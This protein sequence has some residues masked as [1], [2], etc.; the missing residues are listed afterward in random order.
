MN[1]TSLKAG[2]AATQ[3][4]GDA[5]RSAGFPRS[6]RR[7]ALP[8]CLVAFTL[9]ELLVVIAIIGIL[10]GILIPAVGAV[11][12]SAKDAGTKALLNALGTGLETYKADAKL[13]GLYPPSFSDADGSNMPASMV[14]SPYVG[15]TMQISG[16]GLL[17]WALSG[18]DLLGTPGFAPL[19]TAAQWSQSTAGGSYTEDPTPFGA[20]YGLYSDPDRLNQPIHAR[21][22]PYVDGSKVV[23]TRN[24]LQAPNV[25]FA[26]P[27]EKKVNPSAPTRS[28]PMYLDTYGYPVLYWRADSAGRQMAD[29]NRG[30]TNTQRGIYHWEDNAALLDPIPPVPQ[31]AQVLSLN[32][33]GGTH[34]LG[35]DMEF[36]T[37]AAGTALVN[38]SFP[39]FI[40]NENVNARF[41]PSRPDSYLLVSPGFDGLYG[42]ADDSTNFDHH[43]Q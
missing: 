33:G 13:G 39:R 6:S 37:V 16:A 8:R 19:G 21:Y 27:E 32:K 22:G 15:M 40:C 2:D 36:R 29:F 42:T 20:L 43:G 24:V 34:V 14:N 30:E 25:D 35:W 38:P 5:V 17:V 4:R 1:P 31:V 26:I 28:Y 9:V 7:S 18:A 12:R 3:R 41:E 10:I 23:V 11:R